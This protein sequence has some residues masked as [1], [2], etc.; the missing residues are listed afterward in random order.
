MEGN[1]ILLG[2]IVMTDKLVTYNMEDQSIGWTD[3]NCSS[4]IKVRDEETG[5]VYEVGAHDITWAGSSRANVPVFVLLMF[6]IATK[7][8][9]H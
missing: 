9:I 5:M 2:D 3:Y 4:S 1:A 6:I 8:V 7:I